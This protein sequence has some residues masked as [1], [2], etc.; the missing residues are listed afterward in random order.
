MG[1]SRG[2]LDTQLL[3]R[4][5]GRPPLRIRFVQLDP[6]SVQAFFAG[7]AAMV[8]IEDPA[9]SS[10]AA[11]TESARA[12][13]GL[14][15]AELRVARRLIEGLTLAEIAAVDGVSPLTVRSQLKSIFAKTDTRRQA[16]VVRKLSAGV[17]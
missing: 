9:I 8:L 4:D 7:A 15:A 14:T 5:G 2:L 10:V 6:S 1:L 17:L 12:A 3:R 13:Y 16:E 11:R